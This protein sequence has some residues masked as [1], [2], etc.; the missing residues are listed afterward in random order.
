MLQVMGI[1][2]EV[3]D[4]TADEIELMLKERGV[5][6]NSL[7][8]GSSH[9][10]SFESVVESELQDLEVYL[11]DTGLSFSEVSGALGLAREKWKGVYEKMEQKSARQIAILS[12]GLG[13]LLIG[14][15]QIAEELV[16]SGRVKGIGTAWKDLVG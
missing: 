15:I 2:E 16:G 7:L 14:Q 3:V 6:S 13:L 12:A 9:R 10:R 8:G 1:E 11:G 4:G 5:S